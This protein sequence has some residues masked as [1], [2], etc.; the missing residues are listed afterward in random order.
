MAACRRG[1]LDIIKYL[2]D[3]G[4]ATI[5][6]DEGK[7][8][9]TFIMEACRKGSPAC[10]RFLLTQGTSFEEVDPE[11]RSSLWSLCSL[12]ISP[13]TGLQSAHVRS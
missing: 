1:Q 12:L 2:L 9:P 13:T 3:N 11:V 5:K 7:V 4:H 6:T 10:I 8:D